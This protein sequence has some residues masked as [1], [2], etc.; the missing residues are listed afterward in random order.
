MTTKYLNTI[1]NELNYDFATFTL[2]GFIKHLSQHTGRTINLQPL[3]IDAHI[4]GAWISDAECSQEYI[5]YRESLLPVHIQHTV[6]H[7]LAHFILGHSTYQATN[8]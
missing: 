3:P 1:L 4:F 6:L 8:D 7:E 5:F 2:T